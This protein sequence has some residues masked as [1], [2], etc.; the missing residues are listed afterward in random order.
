MSD[1]M[2]P[3]KSSDLVV[4]MH[5][6]SKHPETCAAVVRQQ[7]DLRRLSAERMGEILGISRSSVQRRRRQV[8]ATPV[9]F[10]E[11]MLLSAFLEIPIEVLVQRPSAVMLWVA[12]NQAAYL[13]EDFGYLDLAT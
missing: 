12:Q 4:L 5:Q 13:D 7:S 6:V 1:V 2:E 11:M 10:E 8:D 9:S 3:V